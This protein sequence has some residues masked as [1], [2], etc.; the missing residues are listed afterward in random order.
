MAGFAIVFV[1]TMK[2][3]AVMAAA[4]ADLM[5][6]LRR[7]VAALAMFASAAAVTGAGMALVAWVTLS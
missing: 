5:A 2:A 6:I 3:T 4:L 1:V 7:V